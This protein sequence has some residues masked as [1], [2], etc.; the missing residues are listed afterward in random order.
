M[1]KILTGVLATVVTQLL[2]ALIYHL[3]SKTNNKLIS[4]NK[5][6]YFL[7]NS[8]RFYKNG[9]KNIYCSRKEILKRKPA[10]MLAYIDTAKE[11]FEYVGIFFPINGEEHKVNATRACFQRM[12]SKKV[13]IKLFV[14]DPEISDNKLAIL[15]DYF[16]KDIQYLRNEILKSWTF[17]KRFENEFKEYFEI[18]THDKLLFNSAFLIDYNTEHAETFLDIKF[19][20]MDNREK[21]LAIQL[22]KK[23]IGYDSL[24]SIVTDSFRQIDMYDK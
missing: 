24:Y 5:L 22:S 1:E 4:L 11:T 15:A 2:L 21:T 6:Y 13:K 18:K 16:D 7:K 14:W 8:P 19:Y 17:I 20:K 23:D 10:K 9:I 12:I 3:I